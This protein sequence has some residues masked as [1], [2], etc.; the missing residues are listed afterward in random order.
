[1]PMAPAV[2]QS[3]QQS[4]VIGPANSTA[5]DSWWPIPPRMLSDLS[6]ITFDGLSNRA[7]RATEDAAQKD[8]DISVLVLDRAT[9]RT[10]S[11]GRIPPIVTASVV[12][13]FIADD[14]LQH[15]PAPSADD[16]ASLDAML[17]SS[18]DNAGEE[19]WWRGGGGAIV[20]RVAER[21][22]LRSTFPPPD[23][24]WW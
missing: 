22:G 5:S 17:R 1:K 10:A 6:D 18:D 24:Q 8:A 4:D 7:R 12:N 20:S 21:Y 15:V 14:F 23:G 16:R 13:L 2:A 19:F 3:I 11:N 9:G